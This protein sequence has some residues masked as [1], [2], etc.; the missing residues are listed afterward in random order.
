MLKLFD[1]KQNRQD[2]QE[3]Y[4]QKGREAGQLDWLYRND[5]TSLKER[6]MRSFTAAGYTVFYRDFLTGYLQEV[7]RWKR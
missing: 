6:T 4:C 3:F 2:K 7:E 5:F 1:A